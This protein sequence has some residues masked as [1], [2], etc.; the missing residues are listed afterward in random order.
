MGTY[1]DRIKKGQN[2]IVFKR[3]EPL[4]R[5]IPIEEDRWETVI[6]FTKI[7]KGGVSIDEL[8]KRL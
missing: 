1:V 3:S 5:I 2:F 7:K 8:L 4:F 6:D